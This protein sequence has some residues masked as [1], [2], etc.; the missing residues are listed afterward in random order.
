MISIYLFIWVHQILV[1]A[2]GIWFPDQRSNP[3][4]LL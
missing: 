2:G 1:A 4:P 3:G